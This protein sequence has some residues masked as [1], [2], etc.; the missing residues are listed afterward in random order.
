MDYSIPILT[1]KLAGLPVYKVYPETMKDAVRVRCLSL[2]APRAALWIEVIKGF[3][4]SPGVG[5]LM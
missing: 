1:V 3:M 2:P 5:W 4:G